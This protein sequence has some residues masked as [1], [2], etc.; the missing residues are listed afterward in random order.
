[1]LTRKE[2]MARP[3]VDDKT[4]MK[5]H[6]EYMSQFVD[7]YLIEAV[8]NRFGIK[9]LAECLPLDRHLNNIPLRQWDMMAY[10]VQMYSE[11]K[12]KLK[13]AGDF[14]SLSHGVSVTKEAA[15]IAVEQYNVAR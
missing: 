2:Y 4:A 14:Y 10:T 1:M 8:V 12:R 6:R 11:D 9:K 15:R 5:N 3:Y 7:E 13:E